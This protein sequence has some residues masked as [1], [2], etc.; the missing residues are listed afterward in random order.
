MDMRP[1]PRQQE[2]MDRAYKLAIERFARRAAKHDREASFPLDDYADLH[3]AG[4]LAL[5]IPEACGGLGADFETYCLVAEQL[6]RG[7][8]STALTYTCMPSRC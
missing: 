8:G 2:L 3:A 5:C 4:L 7:N 1:S 6:A